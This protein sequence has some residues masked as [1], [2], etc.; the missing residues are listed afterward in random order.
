MLEEIDRQAGKNMSPIHY[1]WVNTTCHEEAFKYFNVDPTMLPTVVFMHVNHNKH[2][3][4]IG[5]FD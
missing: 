3:S 1:T 2:A 5:K 4:M